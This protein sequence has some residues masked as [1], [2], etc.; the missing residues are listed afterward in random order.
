MYSLREQL[1]NQFR[2]TQKAQ[3]AERQASESK[4]L[5]VSYIFHEVRVPL[6]TALLSVQLLEGEQVFQ[7]LEPESKEMVTGLSSSLI[8]M[9]RVLN[10]VL[11]INRMDSGK[12]N[13]SLSVSLALT[14]RTH[15]HRSV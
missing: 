1:K 10:D 12:L 13:L 3:V 6:N 15:A 4:R 14:S 8:T 7:N 5:F 9:S 11:D 2:A